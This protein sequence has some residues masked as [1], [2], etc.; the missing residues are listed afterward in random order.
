MTCTGVTM[1]TAV[2]ETVC[3][4][5]EVKGRKMGK[6]ELCIW[7]KAAYVRVDLVVI[8]SEANDHMSHD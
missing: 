4:Y 7:Q 2:A 5:G 3:F 8:G 1:T 6:T